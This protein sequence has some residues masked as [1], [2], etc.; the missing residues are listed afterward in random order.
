MSGRMVSANFSVA[1]TDSHSRAERQ[2]HRGSESIVERKVRLIEKAEA[3]FE[4]HRH[5]W[6]SDRY[7][8]LLKKDAPAPSL[9]P[10]GIVEDRASHLMRAAC[11]LVD[12]KQAGRIRSIE[13][14]LLPNLKREMSERLSR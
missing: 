10:P 11:H 7:Y 8:T 9:K 13:R 14:A 3:H 5:R 4:K 6:V 12:R 2:P 1:A